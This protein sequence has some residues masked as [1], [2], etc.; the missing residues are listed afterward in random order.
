MAGVNSGEPAKATWLTG[1]AGLLILVVAIVMMAVS[2]PAH[3]QV[4]AHQVA[5]TSDAAS[6]RTYCPC[7]S[8]YEPMISIPRSYELVKEFVKT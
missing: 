5:L 7:P 3:P 6:V 4:A 8:A 1:A 2:A